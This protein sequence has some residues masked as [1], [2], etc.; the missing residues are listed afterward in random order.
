MSDIVVTWPRTRS[1]DSYV[2]ELRKSDPITG[3]LMAPGNYIV[4]E[5]VWFPIARE[6]EMRG[7]QGWRYFTRP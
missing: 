3:E 6:I 1:L 7:F 4:R 5:P 2:N